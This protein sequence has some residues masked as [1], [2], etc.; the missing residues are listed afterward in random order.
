[1]SFRNNAVCQAHC[2]PHSSNF[3]ANLPALPSGFDDQNYVKAASRGTC[4]WYPTNAER[5]KNMKWDS[6]PTC[7]TAFF[8][9]TPSASFASSLASIFSLPPR[10]HS[11]T[12]LS[13]FQALDPC[14][15]PAQC[16][17]VPG[18]VSRSG[19]DRQIVGEEG[20]GLSLDLCNVVNNIFSDQQMIQR[21]KPTAR[22]K[23]E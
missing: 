3:L 18:I 15:L 16:E 9:H 4:Q 1:M 2:T 23:S 7:T 6:G 20:G 21:Q 22:K 17:G 8:I 11:H 5:T 10:G 14:S 19:R 13:E 12:Q